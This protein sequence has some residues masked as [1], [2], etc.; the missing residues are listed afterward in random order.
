[1]SEPLSLVLAAAAG[2]LLARATRALDLVCWMLSYLAIAPLAFFLLFVFGSPAHDLLFPTAVAAADVQIEA[3]P[4][5][6]VL[7]VDELPLASILDRD[8]AAI[9]ARRFPNLAR[10]ADD[11]IWYPDA[12]SVAAYT[13]G[14]VPAILTGR[15]GPRR[16]PAADAQ[17][18]PRHA[19]HPAGRRLRDPGHRAADPALHG[20]HLR[21]RH[22]RP[23]GP[24]G[25]RAA[26]RPGRGRRAGGAAGDARRL[27]ADHRRHLGQL[28]PGERLDL[29]VEAEELAED[30]EEFVESLGEQDRV[31]D[32]QRAIRRRRGVPEPA[33]SDL[34]RHWCSSTSRGWTW[35]T[36]RRTPTSAT[37]A[38]VHNGWVDAA[39][40]DRALQRHLLQSQFADRLV[41][42]LLDRLDEIG[43]YD[44]A[45]VVLTADHGASFATGTHRRLPE[46]ASLS[47][48]MPVPMVVKLPDDMPVAEHVDDRPAQTVDLL[49]TIA[50]VLGVEVPWEL[51]GRSLLGPRPLE[52]EERGH[53]RPRR[54]DEH[55][56][57]P[58]RPHPDRRPHLGALSGPERTS[59]SST[60]W[61]PAPS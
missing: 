58:A 13:H 11:G 55:R 41:G 4:P 35:P 52:P 46:E 8:A 29:D 18:L 28:R 50:D 54:D 60:G 12:T 37:P 25:R 17:R 9:D 27:A 2:W 7:V 22:R 61:G 32:L 19:L 23:A 56:R 43:T 30:R 33:G 1:M 57:R 36:A 42:D 20:L 14:A 47:G 10:L 40:G 24:G 49:P 38:L 21:Q 31:G 26:G 44:D 45:L 39:A 5:V 15:E 59:S 51:D 3:G 6:V 53:Q 48:L 16:Q 34:H